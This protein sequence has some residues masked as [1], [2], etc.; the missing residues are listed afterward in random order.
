MDLIAIEHGTTVAA[1]KM[2]EMRSI[3]EA[4]ERFRNEILEGLLSASPDDRARALQLSSDLGSRL[5]APYA[6]VLVGPDS[7][8]GTTLTKIE[9]LEKRNIE[10]SLHLGERYIRAL[11]PDA[12]FWYLGPRLVVFLPLPAA[13]LAESRTRLV[14]ELQGVCDRIRLENTPY[15]VSMGV[16]PGVFALEDFRVGYECARQSLQ[17]GSPLQAEVSGR[18][19]PYEDLGL[20]RI[21]SIAESPAGLERF[22]LDAIGPLLAHDRDHDTKLAETLRTFLEQNQ[23]SAK[24]AKLLYIHYNTLRYRLDRAK[25]ILGDFLANPQQRLEIE[26]A[27]QIYPLIGRAPHADRPR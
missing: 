9:S 24:T 1:L 2:M 6:L 3:A 8:R 18:V 5:A 14:Q 23:N 13:R 26:L 20:F 4:E 25:E 27:L 16:S 12:S 17:L 15:T 10:A 21:V 11:Q 19:T 22:C 7:P